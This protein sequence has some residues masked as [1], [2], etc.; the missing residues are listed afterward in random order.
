MLIAAAI[1]CC[2]IP[3][4]PGCDQ[5][6]E[7]YFEEREVAAIQNAIQAADVCIYC[8]N[9][10]FRLPQR[11]MN[12]ERRA[13]IAD[14]FGGALASLQFRGQRERDGRIFETYGIVYVS[15]PYEARPAP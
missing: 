8:I 4:R 2:S 1:T 10:G 7:A 11:G 15:D 6:G 12:A 9:W 5:C 3:F 14:M 13:E